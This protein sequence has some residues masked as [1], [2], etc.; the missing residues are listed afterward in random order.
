MKK[1]LLLVITAFIYGCSS[2]GGDSA[3]ASKD[4]FSLWTEDGTNS[5]FDFTGG[6]FSNSFPFTLFFVGGE[7]CNCDLT[8]LG[9][10]AS[11]SWILNSCVYDFGS[12]SGDPG[13]NALN[14]TG[15][16]SKASTILTITNSTGETDT[17]R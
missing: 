13:C 11:G 6:S 5:K 8:F 7:A 3:P 1:I 14:S 9:T 10:Q 2:G 12:G 4:L 17:Y 16:Y 15:T